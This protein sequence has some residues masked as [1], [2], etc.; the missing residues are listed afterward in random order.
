M[1][2]T[3]LYEAP[4]SQVLEGFLL[5]MWGVGRLGQVRSK[6][7]LLGKQGFHHS[8]WCPHIQGHHKDPRL[9]T[10]QRWVTPGL[11]CAMALALGPSKHSKCCAASYCLVA[12]SESPASPPSPPGPPAVIPERAPRTAGRC[13]AHLPR[14]EGTRLP[15]RVTPSQAGPWGPWMARVCRL[16]SLSRGGEGTGVSV[17]IQAVL[18][19]DNSFSFSASTKHHTRNKNWPS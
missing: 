8:Q 6:A 11:F 7:G 5:G 13:P 17:G 14:C 4:V 15:L 3:G 19:G 18:D 1:P 2:S 10:G 12:S 9:C 16:L